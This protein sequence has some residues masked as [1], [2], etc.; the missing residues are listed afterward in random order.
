M[1]IFN[2]IVTSFR[3]LFKFFKNRFA[4]VFGAGGIFVVFVDFIKDFIK[5]YLLDDIRILYKSIVSFLSLY[6]FKLT[7]VTILITVT[8]K[9]L[10]FLFNYFFE[11][12]I[13][14]TILSNLYQYKFFNDIVFIFNDLGFFNA[15]S[16]YFNFVILAIFLRF[17]L[18]FLFFKN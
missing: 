9:I 11:S 12:N 10:S 2:L 16:I 5:K 4:S 18:N 6:F 13:Y 14:T 15:I 7:L 1:S 3:F 8:Y 17:Y